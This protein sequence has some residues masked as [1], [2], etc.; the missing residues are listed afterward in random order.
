MA[1]YALITGASSGIG[2]ATAFALAKKGYDLVIASRSLEKLEAVKK[3][4]AHRARRH[5][6]GGHPSDD[7][8]RARKIRRTGRARQ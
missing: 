7:G 2:R 8:G 4:D 1:K 6:H 3:R 5:G